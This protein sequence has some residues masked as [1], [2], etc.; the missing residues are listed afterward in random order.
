[1]EKKLN[2]RHLDVVNFARDAL[3]LKGEGMLAD[4]PRLA[5]E[6]FGSAMP[7]G[8]VVWQLQGRSVPQP[9]ASDQIWLD[10]QARVDLPMQCQRCLTPVLETVKADRSFRFVADEATAAALDDEVEEDI[11]VISRDFDALSLIEDELILSLPLVPLHEKCPE[12]LPMS[13]AD[14]EFEAAAQ[15]PNPFGVLAGLKSDRST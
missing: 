14:P 12:A 13:A 8:P 11:L 15:R 4:W 1:M 7:A 9:G 2:P 6:L 10:L 5:Q 3:S